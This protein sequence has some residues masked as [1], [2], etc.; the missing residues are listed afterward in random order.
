V[1]ERQSQAEP[2]LLW[3]STHNRSSSS[4]GGKKANLRGGQSLKRRRKKKRR[5][6]MKHPGRGNQ[7][8]SPR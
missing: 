3:V 2:G 5:R 7:K 4:P 6:F 8:A 1:R